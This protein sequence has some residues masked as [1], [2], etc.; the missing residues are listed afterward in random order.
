VSGLPV[1]A[2]WFRA[3]VVGDGVTRLIE[4]PIAYF[5]E[6][7]I[8]HVRGRDR[9]LVVD[10]GNGFGDLRSGLAPLTEDRDVIAVATHAHFDHI[11]CLWRFDERLVHRA[12][13]ADVREPWAIAVRREDWPDGLAREIEWYGHEVPDSVLTAVPSAD[14]D[15]EGWR[16]HPA[17]PTSE[18]DDGDLVDLGDRVFEVLHVPGHTVGSIALWEA[19]SGTLFT[20]DTMYLD[21]KLFV[22][23]PAA[24]RASLE[25]LREMPVQIVHPGHNRSFSGEELRDAIDRGSEQPQ[26]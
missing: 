9:D 22:D 5:F 6:S 24:F 8:F 4:V 3:E 16:T 18:L 11:G 13:A 19:G 14:F 25:R 21:D 23:D 15:L 12:D 2:E 10:T 26:P 7:N 17:E 1:A 20:G